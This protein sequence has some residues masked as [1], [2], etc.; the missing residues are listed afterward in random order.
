[1]SMSTAESLR[2]LPNNGDVV[3]LFWSDAKR[4]IQT[5]DLLLCRKSSLEGHAISVITQ[6]SKVHAAMAGWVVDECHLHRQLMMCETIQH[7][8]ARA[9]DLEAEVERWPGYY[10]VYRPLHWSIPGGQQIAWYWIRRST[11]SC[12]GWNYIWRIWLRRSSAK[13][14]GRFLFFVGRERGRRWGKAIARTVIPAIQNSEIPGTNRDCSA[15][16]HAAMRQGGGPQVEK[17]DCDVAPGDLTDPSKF[18]YIGT[19]FPDP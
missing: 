17:Y 2:A 5:A 10:D 1:M 15:L 6:S 13:W 7:K 11:G 18:G 9:I 8:A 16:D 14:L 19:L 12:Y 4:V 3:K